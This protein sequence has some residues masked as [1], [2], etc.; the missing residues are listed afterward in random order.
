MAWRCL[1]VSV[2][3]LATFFSAGAAA[4]RQLDKYDI[5]SLCA[6]S[7]LIVRGELGAATEVQTRD[8]D[9]AVWEVTV[10]SVLHGEARPGAVIRVAGVEEYRKGP[11]IGRTQAI[12]RLAKGDVVY[13]FLAPKKAPI[14]YAKYSLTDADWKV[15]ESGARLVAED[16]VHAF[17]QYRARTEPGQLVTGSQGFVAMTEQAF[18]GSPIPSAETFEKQVRDSLRFVAELRRKLSENKLGEP[19][20]NAI[21]EARPA[22]LKEQWAHTD[23][24]PY[25]IHDEPR[26]PTTRP[27]EATIRRVE[28]I[29]GVA[30]A[31]ISRGREDGLRRDMRFYVLNDKDEA[32]GTLTIT[33]V[34]EQVSIGRLSDVDLAHVTEGMLVRHRP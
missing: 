21:L 25:L 18:P 22:V 28:T 14:G 34:D 24:I 15:V 9:C 26:H 30:Y 32:I 31:L 4:E 20:K 7:G 19:E 5:E 6:L 17:A 3:L 2:V 29:G 13:L 23:Y 1:R 16:R 11:G 10:L 33:E 12:R 27:I 8:G